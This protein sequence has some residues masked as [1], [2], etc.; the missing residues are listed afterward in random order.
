MFH[1]GAKALDIFGVA[2]FRDILKT[3]IH[4][5]DSNPPTFLIVLLLQFLKIRISLFGIDVEHFS[6][7]FG[8]EGLAP[9][10]HHGFKSGLD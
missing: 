3:F 6:C 7:E 2:T 10:E 9:N 1:R 4:F 8:R 5:P